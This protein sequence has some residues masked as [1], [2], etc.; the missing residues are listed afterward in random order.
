MKAVQLSLIVIMAFILAKKFNRV[1]LGCLKGNDVKSGQALLPKL[2]FTDRDKTSIVYSN[3]TLKWSEWNN[4]LEDVA[5]RCAES[6]AKTG[7]QYFG[8]QFFGECWSGPFTQGNA[9]L[10]SVKSGKCLGK[11]NK[12]CSDF[13][14]YCVGEAGTIFIYQQ[15]KDVDECASKPCQ[16]GAE[17]IDGDNSYEC[18]CKPGFKGKNC[19]TKYVVLP[20]ECKNYKTL[21][22][23][24]RSMKV[25][26]SYLKCDKDLNKG[27]YRF[28][29][30]AGTSIATEC[31]PRRHCGAHAP[32]WMKGNHPSQAHGAVTRQA[33]YNWRGNCCYW[34]NSIRVRNCGGFYV[35]EL[36]KTPACRLRYCGNGE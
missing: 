8:I 36:D 17:C 3:I 32:G 18:K 29:G 4:Y 20:F 1:S 10:H 21:N 7:Y 9:G 28:E 35:Y 11:D 13:A 23:R 5:C 30:E 27:W 22:A 15:Q 2:L 14:E 12:K 16:N 33:C 19:E 31:P 34:T 26:A 25:R 24:D 6:A